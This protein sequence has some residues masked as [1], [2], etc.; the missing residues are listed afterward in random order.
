MG[1]V[2]RHCEGTGSFASWSGD[3]IKGNVHLRLGQMRAAT[4]PERVPVL[5]RWFVAGKLQNYRRLLTRWSWDA[6]PGHRNHLIRQQ[7]AIAARLGSL[8]G[9]VDGDRIRGIEGDATRRYFKGLAAQLASTGSNLFFTGRNRRPP[10]D[11]VN[12]LLSFNYGLVLTELVGALDAVGLDPQIG[13]L[14]GVRSGRP[15][16]AL[17]LL[18]ELRPAFADRLAVRL[19]ARRQIR[20]EHFLVTPGGACYLTDEGRSI[21]VR[22]YELFKDEEVPHILLERTVPRWTLPTLQATLLAR[23]LRGDIPAYPPFVMAP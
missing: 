14:H 23:H 16:L 10:R 21:L 9:A 11:P 15:A 4:D 20:S 17:D 5:A 22:G 6:E 2:S 7:E 8:A 1:F 12:A 19:I 3:L 18:E 13:F